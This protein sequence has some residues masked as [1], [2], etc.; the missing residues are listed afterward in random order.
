MNIVL[1]AI[2]DSAAMLPVSKFAPVLAELLG[3]QVETLHVEASDSIR[4]TTAFRESLRVP[5]HRRR[6]HVATEIAAAAKEHGV[7]A[8]VVGTRG[9]PSA[10]AA[11][12]GHVTM[13]LVQ[14]L[15][16][17]VA[18]VPPQ[19]ETGPINRVLVAVENDG[20]SSTLRHL[21]HTLRRRPKVE[22]VALHVFEPDR[23]PL[24]GDE[25]VLEAEAFTAEFGRRVLR[26]NERDVPIELRVGDVGNSLRETATELHADLVEAPEIVRRVTGTG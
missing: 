17:A 7:I 26:S 5:F 6:G 9:A 20:E 14:L 16:V 19:A 13:E 11:P 15:D 23:L 10:S 18:V 2:D 24:F 21:V 22:I 8:V 25:P 12:A 3:A 1:A 4:A